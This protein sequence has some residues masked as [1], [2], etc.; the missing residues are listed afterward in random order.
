MQREVRLLSME[1]LFSKNY[2]Q[3]GIKVRRKVAPGEPGSR[4]VGKVMGGTLSGD[5]HFV[6]WGH[7][8]GRRMELIDTSELEQVFESSLQAVDRPRAAKDKR[9]TTAS[10]VPLPTRERKD[11]A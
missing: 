6:M 4:E 8:N 10:I 11:W 1:T 2:L 5:R 3:F 7:G 9:A